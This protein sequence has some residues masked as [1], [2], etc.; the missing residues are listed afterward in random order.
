MSKKD[1]IAEKLAKYLPQEGLYHVVDLLLEHRPKFRI[2]QPRKSK[3][4][5][6]RYDIRDQSEQITINGNLNPYSFYITTIHEFAHLIAYKTF[7]RKIAPHGEEWKHTFSILLHKGA[8][9][10]WF[11]PE[12]R[13]I[14]KKYMNNP[15]ASTATDQ[16]LYIA[17]RNYDQGERHETNRLYLRQLSVGS[18][19]ELNGRKFRML[20]KR[21]T[22]FLCEE[23][24]SGHQFLVSGLAEVEKID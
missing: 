19:F 14:L 8:V 17:L 6:Y 5:D 15:K 1:Q 16:A 23:L 18:V 4:G 24:S 10:Q 21:R 2:T 9:L 22:R 3:F 12:I 11:P 20:V 7:G 13:L